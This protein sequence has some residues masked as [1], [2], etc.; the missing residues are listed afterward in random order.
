M[1]KIDARWLRDN[2][3]YFY[4][5]LMFPS[6]IGVG[7][8]MGWVVDHFFHTDPWGKIGG[9]LF[10]VFAGFVNFVRDYKNIQGKQKNESQKYKEARYNSSDTGSG[11]PD[12]PTE[13]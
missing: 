8:A 2:A 3:N 11:G 12:R 1:F 6:C 7:V 5:G 13:L 4:M 10:G 9:F